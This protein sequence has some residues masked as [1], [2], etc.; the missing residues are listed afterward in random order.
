MVELLGY[1]QSSGRR[2]PARVRSGHASCPPRSHWILSRLL[3][4]SDDDTAHS[5]RSR[6]TGQPLIYPR[7]RLPHPDSPGFQVRVHSFTS[8]SS[9]LKPCAALIM[10]TL[11]Q[12]FSKASFPVCPTLSAHCYLCYRVG[13][14]TLRPFPREPD[15]RRQEFK[16]TSGGGEPRRRRGGRSSSIYS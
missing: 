3:L 15:A 4:G 8:G 13:W 5:R 14:P 6:A 9:L 7:V 1:T 11:L 12:G 16:G 2:G 10:A